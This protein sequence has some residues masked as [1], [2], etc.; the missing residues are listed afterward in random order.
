MER[1][2]I[3][4][5][6]KRIAPSFKELVN[7]LNSRELFQETPQIVDAMKMT[8]E[9]LSDYVHPSFTRIEKR[10]LKGKA[11][12]S[13]RFDSGNFNVIFEL[14]LKT[15]DIVQFLYIKSMSH[16]FDY[17]NAKEF[18]RDTSQYFGLPMEI[19]NL[20]LTLPFSSKLSEGIR[21]HLIQKKRKSRKSTTTA[22]TS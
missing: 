7:R 19:A 12:I 1:Y 11:F 17:K 2:K 10:S 14:G 5:Q 18:L 16:F 3:Y 21:W 6:T 22:K 15:L 8:Y 9:E 20:F 13:P 4:E